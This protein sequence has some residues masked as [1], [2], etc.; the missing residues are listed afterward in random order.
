MAK[1]TSS[2]CGCLLL[3]LLFNILLGGYCFDYVLF[4]VFNKDIPWWADAICGTITGEFI[5]PAA[6]VCWILKIFIP[7]PF[8]G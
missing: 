8:F 4:V 3:V 2:S 1:L 6:I 5:V 7:T